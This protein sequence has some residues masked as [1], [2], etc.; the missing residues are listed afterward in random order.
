MKGA[1]H[2]IFTGRGSSAS[3]ISK[4]NKKDKDNLKQDNPMLFNYFAEV[5]QVQNNHMDES[6]PINY[7]FMLKCC[8]KKG[9]PH[10][11]FTK[12]KKYF[13]LQDCCHNIV[14]IIVNHAIIYAFLA[15]KNLPVSRKP[16]L[17]TY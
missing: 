6:L 15:S 9:C 12:G 10:P 5:W 4:G 1:E 14:N 17:K 7:V 13:E 2:H 3:N 8:G 16:C 11:L